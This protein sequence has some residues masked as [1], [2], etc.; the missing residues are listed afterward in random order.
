MNFKKRENSG[1]KHFDESI[2]ILKS[3]NTEKQIH[4]I[5]ADSYELKLPGSVVKKEY[6]FTVTAKKS[7]SS[8]VFCKRKRFKKIIAKW[9]NAE[10]VMERIFTT[11]SFR[12]GF[13]A[14]VGVIKSK[15]FSEKKK[16]YQRLIIPVK[17]K[18]SF[19]FIIEDR[20]FETPTLHSRGCVRANFE[21]YY[22]DIFPYSDK[23]KN[24]FLIIDCPVKICHDE[25][26]DAAFA[27][28]VTLGYLTGK[29]T[30]NEGVY[31]SYSKKE[32]I[33]P[34]A[35]KFSSFR[36]SISSIQHPVYSNPYGFKVR[37]IKGDRLNKKMNPISEIEFSKLCQQVFNKTDLRAALL[38]LMEVLRESIFTMA[39]GMA[40][41]LE[42]L[43]N[44]YSKENPDYFVY[45]KQPKVSKAILNELRLVV[46][47]HKEQ[48]G[49]LTEKIIDGINRIN[50]VPNAIKLIKPFELLGFELNET[51]KKVISR[52][53]DLLHGRLS[54][55]YT[56]DIEKADSELYLIATKLYTLINV[57]ILKQIG[58]SGYIINWPVYNKHV[59]KQKLKEEVFRMI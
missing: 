42:T 49:E 38:L 13:E 37:G 39:A 55:D 6:E 29:L 59:H 7:I 11:N 28:L 35:L 51:D 19:F 36:P 27:C 25:F 41:I 45:I 48:L 54:L 1:L 20:I 40:V 32:M 4:L 57:L 12:D 22:F 23:E 58:F 21:N 43:T 2:S 34:I 44:L 53:N 16:Q 50:Q 8:G 52:R 56:D 30:Q 31:F 24:D 9:S 33:T 26:G 5:K 17:K 15:E 47:N 18:V 46:N 3:L 14:E 10:F